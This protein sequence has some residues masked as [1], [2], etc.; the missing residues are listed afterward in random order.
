MKNIYVKR[1]LKDYLPFGCYGSVICLLWNAINNLCLTTSFNYILNI[2]IIG[3]LFALIEYIFSFISFKYS[4]TYYVTK[5]IIYL[6]LLYIDI[7]LIQGIP[8][9][10][11]NIISNTFVC[12]GIYFLLQI[13]IYF[14][15]RKDIN[16]INDLL[17]NRT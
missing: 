3:P 15:Y 6:S 4:I 9:I 11:V 16:T 10:L 12:L 8:F 17:K 1:Y 2:L 13:Y 14:I 5:W 7:F